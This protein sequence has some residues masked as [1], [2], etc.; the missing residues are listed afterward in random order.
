MRSTERSAAQPEW[1]ARPPTALADRED[2]G[3]GVEL[4][5][6]GDRHAARLRA[7]SESRRRSWAGIVL[8]R[9]GDVRAS[10]SYAA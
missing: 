7:G 4:V 1:V 2:A 6:D 3:D 10:P 9:L 8:L 5:R